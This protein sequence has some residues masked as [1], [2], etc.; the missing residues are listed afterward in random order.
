MRPQIGP[1]ALNGILLGIL[2]ALVVVYV[3]TAHQSNVAVRFVSDPPGATL[4][5]MDG[6]SVFGVTPVTVSYAASRSC[7]SH[8]GFRATWPDGR[9]MAVNHIEVCSDGG[10]D[11]EVR[12]SAP[13][14]QPTRRE[15]QRPRPIAPH[16]EAEP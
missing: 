3:L 10:D 6:K 16:S 12:F 4:V 13:P 14:V 2:A 15:N 5:S 1:R 9:Q 7:V 11:Q 8:S